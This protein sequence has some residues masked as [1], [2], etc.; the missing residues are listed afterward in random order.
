MKMVL[1][2][3]KIEQNKI[4][5]HYSPANRTGFQSYILWGLFVYIYLETVIT[6]LLNYIV[7]MLPQCVSDQV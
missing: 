5:L 6:N 2:K 3:L 1:N 4:I 7:F